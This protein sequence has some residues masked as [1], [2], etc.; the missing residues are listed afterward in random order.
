MRAGALELDK[1]IDG[2]VAA[3]KAY[4]LV[5]VVGQA[6]VEQIVCAAFTGDVEHND[7]DRPPAACCD[8]CGCTPSASRHLDADHRVIAGRARAL[9][10]LPAGWDRMFP[11]ALAA[12]LSQRAGITQSTIDAA[13]Y[14]A[15]E[16]DQQKLRTFLKGR[17]PDERI[18]IVAQVRRR[19]NK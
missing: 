19:K 12:A 7:A 16:G 9:G 15:R 18:E 6:A 11:E 2:L 4:D 8:V 10:R 1:A 13:K 3:A 17:P 5:R 14:L